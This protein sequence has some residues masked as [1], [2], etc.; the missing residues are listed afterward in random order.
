MA[1]HRQT[2]GATLVGRV[3]F[4]V[5]LAA[6]VVLVTLYAR[7][8]ADGPLH[9]VQNAV[10]D[11]VAPLRFVGAQAGSGVDA[12]EDAAADATADEGTLSALRESNA[13][14]R[15]LVAQTEEY[16]QEA[17]RL[18]GLL[19]MKDRYDI[20]GPSARVIG[21]SATAWNQTITI[22]A[23][24]ADGVEAGMTVMGSTGVVGQI[25]SVSEH[26]SEVRLLTDP[27]SGAAALVQSSRAEG[28]VRGSLEGLL[29]LQDLDED[30]EVAV[31]D[32]VVT[33]GL[34]GS[35]VSGLMIGTVVRVDAGS[36]GSPS[37]VVVSPNDDA[38]SLE[39]VV[40]VRSIGTSD[41]A[42]DAGADAQDG[43]GGDSQ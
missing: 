19:D 13:E 11:A 7:E 15:A 40:V 9:A 38:Q 27:Q 28:I 35:Y 36:G 10:Q 32:S 12:L 37:T 26:S 4:V 33:S 41:D 34:G 29:Y 39:E 6:S 16:R 2:S 43:A 18:Q 8:G 22:D 1:F 31:G 21:R 42:A 3:L 23:G 25:A 5:L 20:D 30:A 24:R 14:L 17:Q